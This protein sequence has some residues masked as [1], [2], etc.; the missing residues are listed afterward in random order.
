MLNVIDTPKRILISLFFIIAV[1]AT[2][3]TISYVNA[4][5]GGGYAED[6]NPDGTGW[7]VRWLYNEEG[8]ASATTAVS[9]STVFGGTRVSSTAGVSASGTDSTGV[10][11]EGAYFMTIP[12]EPSDNGSYEG[13][14][15]KGVSGAATAWFQSPNEVTGSSFAK[16][17]PDRDSDAAPG[18]L[19]W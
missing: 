1:A 16:V 19:R 5:Q 6:I 8:T 15:G 4:N 12:F 14:L 7:V 2:A 10:Q 13:S 3:F 9:K 18:T 17:S 11:N